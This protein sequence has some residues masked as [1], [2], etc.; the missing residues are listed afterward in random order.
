[1]KSIHLTK[2]QI[3]IVEDSDF[4]I[5]SKNKWCALASGKSFY[6][7]RRHYGKFVYMHRQIM[8][9]P[10]GMDTDHINGNKLYNLRS[11]L[12]VVSHAQ[13]TRGFHKSKTKSSQYR[14]V[15]WHKRTSK[16]MARVKFNAIGIYI[17][18][19]TSESEAARA[20]DKKAIELGFSKEALNFQ[21]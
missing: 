16:W 11:N 7:V 3:A 14:G 21:S 15:Q 6:A 18:V 9:T 12:R 5:L 17:G 8:E 2:G 13:N 10:E 1:M 20:Y 4:D 19:F